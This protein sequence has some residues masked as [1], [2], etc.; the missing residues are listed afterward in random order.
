MYCYFWWV[1]CIFF[2][3]VGQKKKRFVWEHF[4]TCNVGVDR[5]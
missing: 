3:I 1:K 5:R 2:V 4:S